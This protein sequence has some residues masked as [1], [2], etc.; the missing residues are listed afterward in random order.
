MLYDEIKSIIKNKNA[1]ICADFNNLSL[2]KGKK[3][4]FNRKC[5]RTYKERDKPQMRMKRKRKQKMKEYKLA[6]N[7][8]VRVRRE[9]EKTRKGYS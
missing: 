9:E 2:N 1:V 7:E 5:D 3:K 4:W 8:Y 6:R